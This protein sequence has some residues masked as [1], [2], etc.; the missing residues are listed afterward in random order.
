MDEYLM[1]RI[2][3]ILFSIHRAMDTCVVPTFWLL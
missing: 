2:Y 3:Y 1:V